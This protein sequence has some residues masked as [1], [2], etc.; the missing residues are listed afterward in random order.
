VPYHTT[1]IISRSVVTDFCKDLG[2]FALWTFYYW[3]YLHWQLS[4]FWWL[5]AS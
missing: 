5:F 2:C 4:N 3:Q 1:F